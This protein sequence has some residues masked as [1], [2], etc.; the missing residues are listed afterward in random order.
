MNR[1]EDI[2]YYNFQG[3]SSGLAHEHGEAGGIY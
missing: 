3:S 2:V 1:I